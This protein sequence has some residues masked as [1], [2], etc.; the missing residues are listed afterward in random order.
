M[1]SSVLLQAERKAMLGAAPVY[2]YQ[3]NRLSP[4][5][6]GKLHCPHGSEI[7]YAFDN[8]DKARAI[9]GDSPQAQVLADKM[10]AVWV[11]F[12]RGGVPYTSDLPHWPAYAPGERAVMVFDEECA[13]VLDPDGRGRR[14][15]AELKARQTA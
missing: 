11:Q 8:L 14:A 15:I 12:A 10:S 4:A 13:V 2:V 7:P 6:D 9:A 5:R 3:F 1:R